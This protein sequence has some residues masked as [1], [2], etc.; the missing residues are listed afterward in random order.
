MKKTILFLIIIMIGSLC[1]GQVTQELVL[2]NL[3][4]NSEVYDIPGVSPD[5]NGYWLC[6][7]PNPVP[8]YNPDLPFTPSGERGWYMI[9]LFTVKGQ[10]TGMAMFPTAAL[11]MHPSEYQLARIESKIDI[12]SNKL[13]QMLKIIMSIRF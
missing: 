2:N 5:I 9:K 3:P 1:F 12:L 8:A 10:V 7:I 4:E 6:W 11:N 13:K